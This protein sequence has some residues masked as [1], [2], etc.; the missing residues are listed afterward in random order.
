MLD[1]EAVKYVIVKNNEAQPSQVR[2]LYAQVE[3]PASEEAP[4]P[5]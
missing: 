5:W 1:D 3:A 2:F 4:A